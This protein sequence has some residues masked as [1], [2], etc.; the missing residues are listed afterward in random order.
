MVNLVKL[1]HFLIT[2]DIFAK[3]EMSL[4]R[5]GKLKVNCK[6]RNRHEYKMYLKTLRYGARYDVI[7]TPA[8]R[9]LIINKKKR[10]GQQI[11]RYYKRCKNDAYA[12]LKKEVEMLKC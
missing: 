12:W 1:A 11:L 8:V 3:S 5:G 6:Q 7:T 10:R 2:T 9:E 4:M